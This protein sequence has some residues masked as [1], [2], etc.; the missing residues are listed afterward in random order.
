MFQSYPFFKFRPS[1]LS[2][3]DKHIA[4][5]SKCTAP[6]G[7]LVTAID[8]LFG[9]Y[10]SAM[11]KMRFSNSS[12]NFFL[13]IPSPC[14]EEIIWS[15]T[16]AD[17]IKLIW[18]NVN[19]RLWFEIYRSNESLTNVSKISTSNG[20]CLKEIFLSCIILVSNPC[21]DF[22]AVASNL[23]FWS[24]SIELMNVR[25]SLLHCPIK[26]SSNSFAP[27][28]SFIRSCNHFSNEF[29]LKVFIVDLTW[30]LLKIL[31]FSSNAISTLSSSDLNSI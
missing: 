11:R 12:S 4:L 18:S 16:V 22:C 19:I 13:S 31:L 7:K 29:L 6:R 15:F 25:A 8:I 26:N 24:L 23:F 1:N 5:S 9:E 3:R 2:T 10:L 30:I 14:V 27:T 28:S 20:I 17:A 21:N